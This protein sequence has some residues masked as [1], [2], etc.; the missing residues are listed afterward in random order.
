MSATRLP[1]DIGR[2]GPDELLVTETFASIQGESTFA[3]EP[4]FFIRL[5]GCPLRCVWCDSEYAFYEGERQPIAKVV[6][7]A[8]E[9]GIRLVEVTGGEPLAQ[10]GALRLLRELCDA[11]HEVLLETSG[12]LP[13][14]RVDPRVRRIVDWKTPGS[15]EVERNHPGVLDALRPRDELKLVILDRA[16][17]EWARDWLLEARKRRPELG[18]SIPVHFSPVFGRCRYDELAAWILADRLG[19]RLNLQIHKHIWRPDARGV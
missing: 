14:D 7:L 16:D 11:D 12:A 5:T 1:R 4:C 17:Y 2:L 3:G 13:I 6:D 15:G 19:V 18:V 10:P 9:S 8:R